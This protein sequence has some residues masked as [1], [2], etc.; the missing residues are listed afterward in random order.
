MPF[1]SFASWA[2]WDSWLFWEF[3]SSGTKVD[4]SSHIKSLLFSSED[5]S[6]WNTLI[7]PIFLT[8]L[9]FLSK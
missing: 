2:N 5:G 8:L 3:A 4:K 1:I 7:S 9:P 6:L